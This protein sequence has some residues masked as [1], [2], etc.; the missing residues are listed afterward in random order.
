MYCRAVSPKKGEN[1]VPTNGVKTTKDDDGWEVATGND[2]ELSSESIIPCSYPHERS[3]ATLRPR[4]IY[5]EAAEILLFEKIKVEQKNKLKNSLS[6]PTDFQN[7]QKK[8]TIMKQNAR[9]D[10]DYKVD[11]TREVSKN[12]ETKSSNTAKDDRYNSL[13]SSNR[14]LGKTKKHNSNK[15]TSQQSVSMQTGSSSNNKLPERK[16]S[17]STKNKEC[18]ASVE[19]S[20]SSKKT[21][22][23]VS[24]P[25]ISPHLGNRTKKQSKTK[26]MVVEKFYKSKNTLALDKKRLCPDD[27]KQNDSELFFDSSHSSRIEK[28]FSTGKC[29]FIMLAK[30]LTI[31]FLYYIAIKTD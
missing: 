5:H 19:S 6:L 4:G 31:I 9:T 22:S 25:S 16:S 21:S 14:K 20:F 30:V 15:G 27:K 7:E 12:T 29:L 26:P 13:I 24:S 18:E 2:L 3:R 10:N 11:D 8:D 1:S 17:V 23:K 28:R